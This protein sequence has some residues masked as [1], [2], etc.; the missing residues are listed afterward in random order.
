MARFL[1][2]DF[3]REGKPSG[4]AA[5]DWTGTS[6]R[7]IDLRLLTVMPDIL[8]WVDSMAPKIP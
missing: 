5:L 4:L 1:G 7:L 2:I 3:G 6:L 8:N